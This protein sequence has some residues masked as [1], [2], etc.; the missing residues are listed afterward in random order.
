MNT[1]LA[2]QELKQPGALDI[3]TSSADPRMMTLIEDISR[4][5][6]DL[7]GRH[8]YTLE[9]TRKYDG[10]GGPELLIDDL[11]SVDASGFKT[12]ETQDRT[13]ETTW[14]TTDYL[15]TPNN[16]DPATSGNPRSRP[17]W[18]VIVDPSGSKGVFTRGLQTVQIAGQ[19]GWWR[20]LKRATETADV[21]AD[22][23]TT[24]VALTPART[25]ILPG[26]TIL[27]ESEQM[28]VQSARGDTL[29]VVRGVNGT[30]AV[31][32]S[33]TDVIDIYEYPPA[34]R[35]ATLIQASR[36]WRRRESAFA[37]VVGFPDGSTQIFSGLDK[38][39]QNNLFPFQRY[40][41]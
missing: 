15:L 19:W 38:D 6:D 20:H 17:Y 40:A 12:D 9:T 5:V 37:N 23:T 27:I 24:D 16:A 13:F 33:G 21:I 30:T 10:G 35:E 18:K 31:S 41:F 25:D 26:H 8:F 28:W 39:V 29:T 36:I 14:A 2:L 7:C 22:A 1:Y 11:I 34:I 4:L 32:H 3:S